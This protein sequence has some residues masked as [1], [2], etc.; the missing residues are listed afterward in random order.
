MI[1]WI[2]H[3]E[4]SHIFTIMGKEK[5]MYLICHLKKF[6]KGKNINEVFLP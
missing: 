5:G 2:C 1:E 3:T 6:W 4:T